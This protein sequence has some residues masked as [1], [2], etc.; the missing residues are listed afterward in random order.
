MQTIGILG[1]MGPEASADVY[2][3]IIQRSYKHARENMD[4][5]PHILINN[6]PTPNIFQRPNQETGAYLGEQVHIL[7][8]AGAKAIG[9]ACNS[10]HLFWPE[11][12][13]A[14]SSGVWLVDMIDEVARKVAHDGHHQVGVL[15]SS[16]SRP[17]Y[18][19]AIAEHSCQTTS[20]TG[21]E[22][23]SVDQIIT[24]ILAGE[25]TSELKDALRSLADNQISRCANCVILGCTDLP[26]I[27]DQADV[28]YPLYASNDVLAEVLFDFAIR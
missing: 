7:E 3:K 6:I 25:R 23:E 28:P 20:L 13:A 15:S 9:V 5:Y 24:S 18:E 27:L 21:S 2:L 11:M 26:I 12:R 16:M 8:V 19:H 22:Q 1:G 10:A 17:L 14:L 4:A